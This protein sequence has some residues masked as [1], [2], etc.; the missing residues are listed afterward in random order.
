M[1]KAD[2]LI[3]EDERLIA[4]DIKISLTDSDFNV[5]GVAASGEDAIQQATEKKP[6]L[7]LMDIVLKG[8]MDG[9]E[10]ADKIYSELKIPVVYLTSHTDSK[11]LQRAKDTEPFGY[12]IKPFQ[13]HE[14]AITIEMAIYKNSMEKERQKLTNKL[15]DALA[16]IE[17]LE[18]LIPI[19]AW[20]KKVRDDQGFWQQIENYISE[21][22]TAVFSHGM[23]PDC[24]EKTRKKMKE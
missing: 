16:R 13:D 17:T 1:S 4:E 10:A 5:V 11:I 14:L 2:I 3:V 22:S 18:G 15:R 8:E 9:I 7:V 24:Y 12:L 23:C 19:C 6:D 20:C 21:H